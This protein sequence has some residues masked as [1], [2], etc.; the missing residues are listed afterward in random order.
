MNIIVLHGPGEV[1]KRHFLIDQKQTFSTESITV[2]D[3]KQSSLSQI[4]TSLS[5]GSLFDAKRLII[6]ENATDDLDLNE[7]QSSDPDLT[8]IIVGQSPSP[9]KTILKTASSVKAK[10]HSFEGEKEV[11]A[12]PFLDALIEKKTQ[13]LVELDKLLEEYGEMYVLTMIY[14]LWRRNIL[15][16]PASSFAAGKI[17][18]QKINYSNTDFAEYYARTL[19]AEAKIK[20]GALPGRLA[21]K[22][23]VQEIII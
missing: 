23:L 16:P 9:T 10:L 17:A 1:A 8:L 22:H 21:V 2:L 13:A 3:G 7:L 12:F 15:P 5:S 18:A 11:S 4:K 20:S 6:I 14:Y 19:D